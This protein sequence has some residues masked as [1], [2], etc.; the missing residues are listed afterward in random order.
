M[1]FASTDIFTAPVRQINGKVELSLDGSTPIEYTPNDTLQSVTVERVGECKFFGF[2]VCHKANIK[3]VDKGRTCN[4]T[5]SHYAQVFFDDISATPKMYVTEV[6]RDE[7]TNVASIT[8][9]DRLYD[10]HNHTL[11]ELGLESYTMRELAQAIAD[12]LGVGLYIPFDFMDDFFVYDGGANFN[13]DETL[14]EVLDDIAEAT[15]TIYYIDAS[16]S[17]C[18][19]GLSKDESDI[20]VAMTIDKSQYFTLDTKTNRRLTKV[21]SATQLGDNVELSTGLTGTTQIV[22]DNGFWTYSGANL[23]WELQNAINNVGDLTATQFSCQWRGCPWIEPGDKIALIDKENNKVYSYLINDSYTYDGTFSQKTEWEYPDEEEVHTNPSSLGDALKM[24]MAKVDKVNQEIGLVVSTTQEA[25]N[26][27]TGDIETLQKQVSLTVDK[28]AV[29]IMID[30]SIGD[31]ATKVETSTGFTFDEEGLTIAKSE[32]D[33]TTT[34]T[35]DGMKVSRGSREV[36]T[37]NN[38]GVKA[39]DLHATTY[40]IIGRNSRLED[41]GSGKTACFWIGG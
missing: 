24:T 7:N 16:N 30:N 3:I 4:P 27:I 10:A 33:I 11:S 26:S 2:G 41:Y 40:L 8:A 12:R 35:E 1:I 20:T 15:Q 18:F 36:L 13:G 6:H 22:W 25:I 32:S 28:D 17:L 19:I 21:V 14:R 34:I 38:E 37:A 31:G 23:E 9:Y 29:Q 39:E 5:T